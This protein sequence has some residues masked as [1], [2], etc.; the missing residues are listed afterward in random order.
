M[1]ERWLVADRVQVR[2][3]FCVPAKLLGHV[4]RATEVLER[5][6]L[7]PHLDVVVASAVAGARKPDPAIFRSALAQLGV[8][9]TAY[10]DSRDS[11][12]FTRS[13]WN[14]R[15]GGSF[16][17]VVFEDGGQRRDRRGEMRNAWHRRDWAVCPSVRLAFDL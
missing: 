5:V 11:P 14:I 3:E 1:L 2:I 6:G 15:A 8:S 16:Y 10:F 12:N 4:D 13:G 7:R 17:P 9:A